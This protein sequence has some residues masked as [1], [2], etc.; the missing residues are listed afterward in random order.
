[1]VFGEPLP[2]DAPSHLALALRLEDEGGL[3]ALL[4]ELQDPASPHFHVWLTPEE[5][6]ARFGLS[7]AD[8]ERVV[9]WLE[10]S[11][12]AV[13]R[14]PNRLFVEANG[15]VAG[16]R[17]LLGV[18]SRWAS[19]GGRSFRSHTED[20]SLP[21]DI[22]VHVARVGGLDTRV[23]LRHRLNLV[24]MGGPTTALGGSDL[25][26]LYDLP[27]GPAAKGLTTVVLATQ[28]G[29]QD[30]AMGN[31]HPPLILPSATAIQAYF[32]TL[33][34][35]TATYVPVVLPNPND[36][37]DVSGSN[38]EY[39]LDVEMQSVGAP[40]AKDIAL[41]LSP[42][43]E[44][45]L[46]GAEYI[47]NTLS[48]AT[49]VSTSIGECE[50]EEMVDDGGPTTP[51]SE[52]YVFRQ[53][54]RQGL[55]EGQTWFSASGD[56]GADD[57]NDFNFSGHSNGYDGGTATVDFPCSIPEMLC[58]GGT[59]FADEGPTTWTATG[60]LS[61]YQ[62]EAAWNEGA[63][64]GAGGGGQSRYYPKPSWQAGVGPMAADSVR[65]V[66]DIALTAATATPG[67][68]VYD[69]GSGQDPYSCTGQTTGTGNLD[70][71]GGT[72]IGSPLAAG[73][74]A[75]MSSQLNC[76]FGDVHAALY[77]LGLA[78]LDGGAA[79]FHDITTGNNTF[80]DQLDASITGYSAGPGY[81]LVTG[82]GSLDV[83]KLTAAWPPCVAGGGTAVDGGIVPGNV[84]GTGD[85]GTPK[86]GCS[87][88]AAGEPTSSSGW[89][90][91][92]GGL[93]LAVLRRRPTRTTAS[94]HDDRRR[95]A[96]ETPRPAGRR[97]TEYEG[98]RG[99]ARRG[100]APCR[101]R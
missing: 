24:Y 25:R 44:V 67:V 58:V 70:I 60:A 12:F 32:S 8:Y 85:A 18:Q 83:A 95:S 41:V 39:Q 3:G 21:P 100:G 31:P 13:T 75:R 10:G 86:T 65:D 55:A 36:D 49:S 28:E 5:Y 92:L 43:S 79:P 11:G 84:P 71:Y 50:V 34:S 77:S 53:A 61:G 47:A 40:S 19:R 7:P 30:S 76:R 81:D 74:F 88:V 33:S 2:D 63:M 38:A 57:C 91:S 93:A 51:G 35:A 73:I 90:L 97:I 23:H 69:C 52:A 96:R 16:V 9:S 14:Y 26:T 48:F 101:I 82:W 56:T 54:V 98:S 27:P 15:T 94:R 64:G 1:V 45:F 89:W 17:G 6:G 78:Q 29:T 46:T 37:F 22:A 20:V 4:A 59:Q 72:S 68:A 99:C 87:C 62:T 42:A 66:P 80:V